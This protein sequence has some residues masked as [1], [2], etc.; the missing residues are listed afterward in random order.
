MGRI[1]FEDHALIKRWG[2]N[3]K[4]ECDGRGFKDEK[5]LGVLSKAIYIGSRAYFR[6]FGVHNI[7][8]AKSA[9]GKLQ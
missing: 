3:K 8:S 5:K 7:M 9:I 2:V 1:N 4:N 6:S